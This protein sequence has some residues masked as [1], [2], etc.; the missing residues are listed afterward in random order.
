MTHRFLFSSKTQLL[1]PDLL[2]TED[3]VVK[4]VIDFKNK[5][6]SSQFGREDLYQMYAYARHLECD[7]V[8]LLYPGEFLT[9]HIEATRGEPLRVTA[10]SVDLSSSWREKLPQLHQQL[11]QHLVQQGLNL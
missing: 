7:Q 11:R 4:L 2:I 9:N 5:R 8:L 10:S 3:G 6:P 1:K